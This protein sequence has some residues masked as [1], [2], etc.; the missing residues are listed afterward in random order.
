MPRATKHKL[1]I[2]AAAGLRGETAVELG[3]GLRV[4]YA[5]M[6]PAIEGPSWGASELLA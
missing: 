1:I 4:P 3:L 6:A 2:L 5:A